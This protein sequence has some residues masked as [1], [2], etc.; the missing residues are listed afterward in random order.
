MATT[1]EPF[2]QHPLLQWIDPRGRGLELGP[3]HRPIA[4]KK[5]GFNVRVLDHL[6]RQGL[7]AKYK[8][9]GVDLDAI[10]E[11][12]YVW[13]GERYADIV[14]REEKFDWIIASH[15]IEHAP[16]FVGF[17]KNCEEI[18]SPD[19]A[20][21]IAVPDKRRCFDRFRPRSSL[22]SVVDAHKSGRKVHSP[23]TAAEY[24]L[25]VVTLNGKI[26]W[27][28]DESGEFR[29]VHGL[30]DAQRVM[31]AIEQ[32]GVY[33][34]LH[35]WVFTPASFRL[36]VR[37]LADL[38]LIGLRE[39]GFQETAGHEFYVALSRIAKASEVSRLE[40]MTNEQ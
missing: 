28:A 7:I 16:D 3:S 1:G 10:E 20:L 8:D 23:G 26:A 27:Q 21:I 30:E 2:N 39:A 11:V 24:F 34:D 5:A 25:N 35:A 15:V 37:D 13:R 22:A 29:N 4:P 6:D 12:D 9:H 32:T 38:G 40:L 31:S 17:L 36:I 33:V 18:L 19:G 14:G